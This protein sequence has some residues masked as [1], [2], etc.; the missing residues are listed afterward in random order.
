MFDKSALQ[1]TEQQEDRLG[2]N[3]FTL[4][5]GVYTGT[6]KL[7]YVTPS[8]TSKSKSVNIVIDVVRDPS[9]PSNTFEY[10]EQI[11]IFNGK[12][13]PTYEKNGKKHVLPGYEMIN[14]MALM[15]TGQP[16]DEQTVED[17]TI[18][19]W[20][21][22][23][24]GEVEKVL[25]TITSMLGKQVD[26]AVLEVRQNKQAKNGAG[27]YVDTNDER[28]VNEVKKF[29]HTPTKRT[30]VEVVK[31]NSGTTIADEDLFY[32]KW[33]EK[34]TGQLQDRYKPVAGAAGKTAGSGS[35]K[36][37]GSSGGGSLFG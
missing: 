28:T 30:F 37:G 4:P 5:S 22:D 13:Q 17:K 14:D 6:I 20:D 35:P 1:G 16:L 32:T 36:T 2:G 26:L 23:A 29:F 15:A 12:G 11:W 33:S 24:K 31:V 10:R 8:A 3:S 25:P 18:K 34:Y 7:A 21:Y 9:N 19:V 27:A